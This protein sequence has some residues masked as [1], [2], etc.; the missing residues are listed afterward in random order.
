MFVK[1]LFSVIYR[2]FYII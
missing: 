1:H 2:I